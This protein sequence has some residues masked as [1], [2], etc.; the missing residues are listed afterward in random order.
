MISK[1]LKKKKLNIQI[2]H[3]Y[4]DSWTLRFN[5]NHLLKKIATKYIENN[6]VNFVDNITCASN[7]IKN[8]IFDNLS[9]KE[10]NIEVIL[11][12]TLIII[13]I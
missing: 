11:M 2:I 6:T 3:D 10:K 5:S 4:R 8:K 9:I 13:K 7:D 12:D 1:Y